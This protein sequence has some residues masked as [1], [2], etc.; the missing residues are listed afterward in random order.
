M[1]MASFG[2]PA[3]PDPHAERTYTYYQHVNCYVNIYA[4]ITVHIFTAHNN[5]SAEVDGSSKLE[6]VPPR[7]V[8]LAHAASECDTVQVDQAY[9]RF[10]WR[11]A[12][13][14]WLVTRL[15]GLLGRISR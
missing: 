12:I 10:G 3:V 6:V 9:K 11:Q 8:S 7:T 4:P 1:R 5:T 15:S 13:L 2:A 14:E